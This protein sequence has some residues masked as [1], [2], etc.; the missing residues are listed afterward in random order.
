MGLR[1][2]QRVFLRGLAHALQPV[3]QVG[4]E[5]ASEAAAAAIDAALTTHELIKV[6]MHQP[7]EKRRLAAELA[8]AAHAELCGL[9]GHTAI[10][11]RPHPTQPR[12][13]LPQREGTGPADPDAQEP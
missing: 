9:V 5:G 4:H 1:G 10:L 3:V 8:G 13:K 2:Y 6:R 11:Y 7:Q 12:L